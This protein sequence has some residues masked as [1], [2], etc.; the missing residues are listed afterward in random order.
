MPFVQIGDIKLHYAEYGSG[1]NNIVFVHGNLGCND[2][3]NLVWPKLS[4]RFHIYAFDWRGCG[5]SDKPE[6]TEDYAN[7]SMRQHATDMINAMK[8]LKIDQCNLV[9]HS[10]GGIICTHMLLLMPELFN[11]VLC[12][13]PVGPQG[14]ELPDG[15][16]EIFQA[17][18]ESADMAF[19]VLAGTAPTLF[20]PESMQPGQMPTFSPTITASQK[21]LFNTIVGNTRKLSDGIWFGTPIQLAKEFESGELIGKLSQIHHEH[22]VLWGEA[23]AWIPKAHVEEMV[24]LLP[25]CKLKIIPNA[26]HSLNLENPDAFV[27]IFKDFFQ[28]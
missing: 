12:L 22:L 16:K 13:D 17:M 19:A 7:Y 21:D 27:K 10:T 25:N 15:S 14:M 28:G 3:M 4:D 26:G 18:K 20:D 5:E 24:K 9:N 6:P 8:A 2:W 11:K 23:D 1:D